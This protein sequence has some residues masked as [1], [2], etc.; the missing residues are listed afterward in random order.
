MTALTADS[1]RKVIRIIYLIIY[2]YSSRGE[3]DNTLIIRRKTGE[4]EITRKTK[5]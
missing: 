2:N 4:K 1:L 5:M 3:E